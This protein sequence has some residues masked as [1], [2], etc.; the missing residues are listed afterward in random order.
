MQLAR[1]RNFI[2][3]KV[4]NEFVWP[5]QNEFLAY[6]IQFQSVQHSQCKLDPQLRFY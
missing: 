2:A 5:P 4:T 6:E 3:A 1:A